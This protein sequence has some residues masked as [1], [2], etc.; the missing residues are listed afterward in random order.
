MM[1]IFDFIGIFE[2]KCRDCTQM[3][4]SLIAL[5]TISLITASFAQ[6]AQKR[7]IFENQSKLTFY[8]LDVESGLS[9]NYI[10][11]IEQDSLGFIWIATLEGLNRYDGQKFTVYRKR[12]SIPNKGPAN[13]Y[14]Q[15]IQLNGANQLLLSTG[16]GLNIYD[17]K[18]DLFELK[19]KSF[20]LIEDNVNCTINTP[21]GHTA[22]GIYRGGLQII[23]EEKVR[24][25]FSHQAEDKQSLSSNQVNALAFQG[26]SILWVGTF[27]KGLNK[28]NYKTKTLYRL[29]SSQIASTINS[30][31]TDDLGNLWIGGNKGIQV[32]TNKGDTVNVQAAS[33]PKDGLS[34]ENVL[35]FE[36]DEK[37]QMWIGTRNGG[38]NIIDPN[39]LLN[40]NQ[41]AIQWFL[42]RNDG[43]SVYNRTVASLKL[44]RDGNMWIGTSTGVNVVNPNGDPIQLIQRNL[45]VSE[46]ISHN[47]I[48]SLASGKDNGI[49]IGTDGGG[50]DHYIP[51]TGQITHYEHQPNIAK[52]LSIL[53]DSQGRVWAGTYQGGLNRLVDPK[54]EFKKY[55]QGGQE[56]G[57][58]VRIIFEGQKGQ[59]WVGTNRGGLYRYHPPIDDF[60]YVK[61]LGKIDIRDITED[62][63]GNLW[64]ATFSN[65][66]IRYNYLTGE[67]EQFDESTVYGF[68]SNIIFSIER[69]Q[70]GDILAGS[71]YEGLIR[72]NP[73]NKTVAVF[74]ENQGL[75]NN[76]I[77]S[78]TKGHDGKI[79][80]GTFRGISFFD[81]N[82]NEVGNL[83]AFNNIQQSEFNIGAALTS[84]A[85]S[86]YFGGNKGINV[87][88]PSALKQQTNKYPLIFTGLRLMNKEVNIGNKEEELS[89]SQNIPYLQQLKLD[90]DQ[91]LV[92][93]DFV[94][95]KY[96]NGNNISYA[97][98]LVPFHDQWIET[99]HIGTA[100]LSNIPPGDYV[101]KVRAHSNS[102]HFAENQIAIII[103][104][105]FWK[106]WPAYLIYLI[107]LVGLI[108][109][110]MKYYADRLKLKNSLLFEKKQRTLEHE[111]NEERARF[112]TGFSHE[113]KTPLTLIMAPIEDMLLETKNAPQKK[114]LLLVQKNAQY[115]LEMIN[116]LLE[117][118]KSELDINQLQL[119]N[120][121]ILSPIQQWVEEYQP[122]AQHRKITLESKFPNEDFVTAIDLE[123]LH[124]IVNN[125]LSNALKYCRP[126]D[127]VSISLQTNTEQY[128][129][130]VS[131]NGPGIPIE[132]QTRI[133]NWYYQSGSTNTSQG[134]GIGLALTK[135]LVEEHQGHISLDSKPGKGC[136]FSVTLPLQKLESDTEIIE[137][138][139][140][141]N[142]TIWS[143]QLDNQV[144]PIPKSTL[145]LKEE[146]QVV[147]LIDD[148]PQILSYLDQLLGERYDLI[149]AG[150]GQEGLEKA[151][152]YVPDII[153]SDIMMPVKNGIDLCGELKSK[154][155]TT[156]I[157]IIL[158]SAK[159]N[160]ESITSGFGEGA[161]DYLTKP[162]NGQILQ[163]RIKNLLEAKIRLRD[164]Y[165]GELADDHK[166]NEGQKTAISKEKAFLQNLE[167]HILEQLAEQ[168]TDVDT[169]SQ[170][171][172]MSRTSLFRKLK[173]LTGKNINQ[174]VRSV[175]IKRAAYL[176]KEENLGVAQAAYEIGFSNP[177]YFRKLFKE[178][179]G[180]LP[181]EIP[182]D[183]KLST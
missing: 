30:L 49:W 170:L 28:I 14:I 121:Y 50:L 47:R 42:P 159:D 72:L 179:Y 9:H 139:Q 167:N 82:T 89:I 67:Q 176:I 128:K 78:I 76:T 138:S 69:L 80:L 31:F 116:K 81:P 147:L 123:K 150:D 130:K 34:D 99:S 74:T 131:D 4:I 146:K 141:S 45:S 132:N 112:F 35:C 94:A 103:A 19:G 127:K 143:P 60:D 156:H 151:L 73:S 63:L 168:Q 108:T 175:K 23:D 1:F 101:L 155:A 106:T 21:D 16:A 109:G 169:L 126:G 33:S 37:G 181:S 102:S 77:N 129:I 66:I 90:H 38:L 137:N 107:V 182:S 54:G 57:N 115:L 142:T 125:L 83:N 79:W 154:K 11:S 12:N 136:T 161:D 95:L 104:P 173:A 44:A 41:L 2:F 135:R 15:Q 93:L 114:G 59:I 96:P 52:S 162:F 110:G 6:E 149:H 26:D 171:M 24:Y 32:I 22:L 71:R 40:K 75:S 86:I 36:K 61:Q 153:I 88:S 145:D 172:G 70:N 140:L 18:T 134:T 152:Q 62:D 29:N 8:L 144:L 58:D 122:L 92:S 97:Y 27:D 85:G 7:S 164:Y 25:S 10:N 87:F 68:P 158:L 119:K 180:Y 17:P 5:F 64:L 39:K 177:K 120:H 46:T 51:Q 100:N 84:N 3:K 174:Y 118:R 124:I 20:G 98:K 55:L 165:L 163:S 13:N 117:F 105:P 65:G 43:A 53:E 166:L 56:K 183:K 91:S 133:F 148:N 113:L 160:V 178:Q 111:L 157:P 48:G